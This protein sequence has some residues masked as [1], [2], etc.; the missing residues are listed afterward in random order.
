MS[1]RASDVDVTNIGRDI[2]PGK[3]KEPL[4]DE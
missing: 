3:L 4:N 2:N 1:K